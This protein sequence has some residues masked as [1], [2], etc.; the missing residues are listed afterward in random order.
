MGGHGTFHCNT[1]GYEEKL[2]SFLH[3]H[4]DDDEPSLAAGFQCQSC[5]KFETYTEKTIQVEPKTCTC[6]GV[7]SRDEVV[8]C[9]ACKSDDVRFDTEFIF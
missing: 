9:P 8:F 3:G 6:G 7:F 2:T 1:C 4:D 5:G